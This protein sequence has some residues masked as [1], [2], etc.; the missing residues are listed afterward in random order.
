LGLENF[1]LS[2]ADLDT[3]FNA[4]DIIGIGPQSLRVIQQHLEAIYCDAIGV[5]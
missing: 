2:S 3:V 4:G 5:E 1:G